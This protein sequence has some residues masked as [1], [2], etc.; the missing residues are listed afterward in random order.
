MKESR[1]ADVNGDQFLRS[2][3]DEDDAALD[4]MAERLVEPER[5]VLLSC[6]LAV[7]VREKL[8]ASIRL[9]DIS[10]YAKKVSSDL[11]SGPRRIVLE[12]VL[13][14]GAGYDRILSG[15][16]EEERLATA[17]A[18]VRYISADLENRTIAKQL[19]IA[20]ALQLAAVQNSGSAE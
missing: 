19:V 14:T 7:L 2:I 9:E 17:V 12:S 5:I 8:G 11:P 1:N 10:A 16:P 6:L 3:L 4:A 15:L 13:R 18:L 20:H